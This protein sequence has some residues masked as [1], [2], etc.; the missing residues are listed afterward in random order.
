MLA[1]SLSARHE[2][3]IKVY[4]DFGTLRSINFLEFFLPRHAAK[5][6]SVATL[7]A[8]PT[9]RSSV[10]VAAIPALTSTVEA[11]TR[12]A[13]GAVHAVAAVGPIAAVHTVAPVTP[14]HAVAAVSI[15]RRAEPALTAHP[16]GIVLAE[17]T[18]ELGSR[19]PGR[20]FF[21]ADT[22][23]CFLRC[24]AHK[25]FFTTGIGCQHFYFY[26]VTS[27]PQLL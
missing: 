6:A 25:H 9:S 10:A 14:V 8:A 19:P 15:H 5:A 16:G 1:G 17:E 26:L 20:C 22:A 18:G 11:P 21:L 12:S 27:A 4:R 3:F 23:S 7:I 2:G 13:A 24:H